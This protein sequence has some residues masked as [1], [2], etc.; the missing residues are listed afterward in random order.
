MTTHPGVWM[1]ADYASAWV[2]INS[3]DVDLI[4]LE[5]AFNDPTVDRFDGI[6]FATMLDTTSYVKIERQSSVVSAPRRYGFIDDSGTPQYYDTATVSYIESCIAVGGKRLHTTIHTPDF[7]YS[8]D[9]A[10]KQ[11]NTVTRKPRDIK[12]YSASAVV[13]SGIVPELKCFL[14]MKPAW[15]PATTHGYDKLNPILICPI[16]NLPTQ[17]A[18]VA[19]DGYIYCL[20]AIEPWLAK[21]KI[22][23]SNGEKMGPRLT[24]VWPVY[25]ETKRAHDD[26]VRTGP[27]SSTDGVKEAEEKDDDDD[28]EASPKKLSPKAKGKMNVPIVKRSTRVTHTPSIH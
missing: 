19:E 24:P 10:M 12:D 21:H 13:P 2:P 20:L 14:N 11:T 8:I 23:P 6:C 16:T 9:L 26:V 3:S 15:D 7:S 1:Q 27:N 22:S 5:A 25:Y 28:E 17:Y 18:V 4:A